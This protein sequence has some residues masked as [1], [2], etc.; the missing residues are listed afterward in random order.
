MS[1]VAKWVAVYLINSAWQI[2]V[3]ALGTAGLVRATARGGARLHYRLWVGCLVLAILL[4]AMPGVGRARGFGRSYSRVSG[5]ELTSREPAR[6]ASVGERVAAVAAEVGAFARTSGGGEL[7]LWLYGLSLVVGVVQF[8]RRLRLTGEVVRGASRMVLPPS[9]SSSLLRS[10]EALGIGPVAV[11]TSP[12]LLCPATVSWPRPMLLVP[13]DFASVREEDAAAAIGHELAHVRRRDFETNL[14]FE[15]MS[16]FAF[17]HPALHWIERRVA[18]S[19]E[20][21][22]DEMAA[23]ATTGRTAYAKSLLSLAESVAV[24]SATPSLL[25]GVFEGNTLERRIMKLIDARLPLSRPYKVALVAGCWLVLAALS[26]GVG[27]LRIR[28]S[29]AQAATVELPAPALKMA[30][31]ETPG[32]H[33]AAIQADLIH[34]PAIKA[35]PAK[36]MLM[37]AALPPP[38]DSGETSGE[39]VRHIGG[40]VSAPMVIYQV[41]PEFSEQARAAKFM[42]IVTVGLT[43]DEQGTPMN[44]H[45]VR[46]V[47]M[48]LDEKAVEAVRQYRFKPALENGQPVSVALNIEVNFQIF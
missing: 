47:G 4:P 33:E 8:G 46:G 38:V 2:P 13:A 23:E 30:V 36:P 35:G 3:L 22:C 15:G 40:D 39:E 11:Y 5:V 25:L 48:G 24:L 32:V 45:V 26:V 17:Y 14:V 7:M 21:L 28:P 18:E 1:D 10:A 31:V 43:V 29:V 44:V 19:R 42:G 16:L 34:L 6:A 9:V 20:V 41:N 12:G 27:A 37:A